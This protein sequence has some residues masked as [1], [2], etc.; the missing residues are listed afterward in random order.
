[1]HSHSLSCPNLTSFRQVGFSRNLNSEDWARALPVFARVRALR[2]DDYERPRLD[3]SVF[4][5]VA[6]TRPILHFLPSLRAL[7][8]ELGCD[9]S[10]S[11]VPLFFTPTLTRLSR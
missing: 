8:L 7:E 10:L 11:S 5:R 4:N 3:S 1:M 2:Y 6:M 9:P